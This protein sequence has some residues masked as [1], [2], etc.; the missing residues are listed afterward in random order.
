MALVLAGCG[1]DAGVSA[2]NPFVG[3]PKWD[4]LISA[5]Q[6]DG[7]LVIYGRPDP[8]LRAVADEF[9]E[10]F[11]VKV[12]TTLGREELQTRIENERKKGIY[13]VDV[14][15][16]GNSGIYSFYKQGFLAPVEPMLLDEVKD[17]KLW[18][19]VGCD[20]TGPL[21]FIDPENS[22]VLRL[23][24]AKVPIGM[25]NTKL[26]KP[27]QLKSFD[28]LITPDLA[29][30]IGLKDPHGGSGAFN[31]DFLRA[32]VGDDFVGKLYSQNSS[33]V[34]KD[35]RQLEEEVLRGTSSLIVA[36]TGTT[37]VDV[38][39]LKEQ[40]QPVEYIWDL[41]GAKYD[42][43]VFSTGLLIEYFKNAP[44]PGAAALFFNWLMTKQ[45]AQSFAENLNFPSTR[46]DLD[47]SWIAAKE[48]IPEDG[49]KYIDP[50]SWKSTEKLM[51]D[52]YF[53]ELIGLT[54]IKR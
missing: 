37:P 13:S 51:S 41:D 34:I 19:C 15:V 18:N 16:D 35:S 9:Q 44:N 46:A 6:K 36:P 39:P 52:G 20:L 24:N 10:L 25:Y 27:E 30:N 28:D 8:G 31:V 22:H 14:M 33:T 45:G 4:E 5:A 29:G 1:S 40:G 50:A 47:N 38:E 3:D 49:K 54:G 48:S 26:V 42:G 12:T 32:M 2:D 17:P 23:V 43:G 11:G 21:P 53:Q 7:E